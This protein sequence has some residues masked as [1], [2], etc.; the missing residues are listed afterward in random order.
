MVRKVIITGVVLGLLMFVVAQS[1]SRDMFK[2]MVNRSTLWCPGGVV[3][4]DEPESV[5]L[6]KCGEPTEIMQNQDV[7]PIWVY[8][9]RNDRFMYYLVVNKGALQR[10]AS[11]PCNQQKYDCFDLR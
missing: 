7:G 1:H 5:V 4:I 9:F 6:D 8:T 3:S 2:F 11:T 10:I